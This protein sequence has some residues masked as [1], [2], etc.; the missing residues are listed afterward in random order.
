LGRLE[1]AEDEAEAIYAKVAGLPPEVQTPELQG[2]LVL[3]H[4][5]LGR[6]DGDRSER[7]SESRHFEQA[8]TL[9]E[10]IETHDVEP[11]WLALRAELLLRLG[12]R[13]EAKPLLQRLRQMNWN[14]SEL[15]RLAR[16][17]R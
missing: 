7:E 1:Q 16:D 6:I 13:P 5:L 14:D 17:L 3:L 11:Q 4:R 2:T 10:Q 8:L 12:R 15:S 9:V